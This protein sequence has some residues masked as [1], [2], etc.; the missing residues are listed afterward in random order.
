MDGIQDLLLTAQRCCGTLQT[1]VTFE[2]YYSGPGEAP[3]DGAHSF[4]RDDNVD[5]DQRLLVHESATG[6]DSNT[7][8]IRRDD[9]SKRYDAATA[10][11]SAFSTRP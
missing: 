6:T 5:D 11:S 2:L 4:Y 10:P 8:T 3:V 1:R 7:S 9:A